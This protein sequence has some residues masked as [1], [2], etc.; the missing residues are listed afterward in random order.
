MGKYVWVVCLLSPLK[1][2][3]ELRTQGFDVFKQ[4]NPIVSGIVWVVIGGVQY[5]K[6]ST[7]L[8]NELISMLLR[9][10]KAF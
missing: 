8:M 10:I 5:N 3:L 2:L 9:S 4:P 1:L 7:K 6:N